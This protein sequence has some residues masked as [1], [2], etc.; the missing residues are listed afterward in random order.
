MCIDP[1]VVGDAPASAPVRRGATLS[2]PAHHVVMR[3]LTDDALS[4]V[5]WI[6]GGAAQN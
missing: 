3:C 5:V 2:R 1:G 6:E 4:T